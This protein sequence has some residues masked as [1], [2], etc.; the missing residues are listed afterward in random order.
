MSTIVKDWLVDGTPLPV[1][2]FQEALELGL[3]VWLE[4][5]MQ[6]GQYQIDAV[7]A[8]GAKASGAGHCFT[9]FAF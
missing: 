9:C 2:T 5:G 6:L 4:T 3:D 1:V 8:A 7:Q